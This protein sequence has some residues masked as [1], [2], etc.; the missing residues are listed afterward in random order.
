MLTQPFFLLAEPLLPDYPR[1]RTESLEHIQRVPDGRYE[2]LL[3]CGHEDAIRDPVGGS[4]DDSPSGTTSSCCTI[5]RDSWRSSP[6]RWRR[7]TARSVGSVIPSPPL[8]AC[9]SP[10]LRGSCRIESLLLSAARPRLGGVLRA[11]MRRR[12]ITDRRTGSRRWPRAGPGHSFPLAPDSQAW[13][14][15]GRGR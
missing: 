5:A 11:A 8:P 14:A 10:R 3:E 6:T 12:A 13:T 7:R 4:A 15:P 2:S 1:R 9:R